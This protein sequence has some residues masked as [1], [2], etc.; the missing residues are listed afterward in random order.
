[1]HTAFTAR[2]AAS[3]AFCTEENC[4]NVKVHATSH[5]YCE[6]ER[7]SANTTL[8]SSVYYSKEHRFIPNKENEK[9][10]LQV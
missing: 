6:K 8:T 4:W 5:L 7:G 2:I 1:M 10:P 3:L 9:V